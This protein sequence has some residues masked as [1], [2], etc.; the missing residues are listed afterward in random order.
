MKSCFC[1]PQQTVGQQP[2]AN[3]KGTSR[4]AVA[5]ERFS[6]MCVCVCLTVR[7]S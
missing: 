6:T 4:A 5:T 2:S 7:G 3:T 1:C